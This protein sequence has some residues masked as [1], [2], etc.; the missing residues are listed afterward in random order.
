MA[1]LMPK[2]ILHHD[3][4]KQLH[5]YVQDGHKPM[6]TCFGSAQMVLHRDNYRLHQP[7]VF[8]EPCCNLCIHLSAMLRYSFYSITLNMWYY[9]CQR[10]FDKPVQL[11]LQRPGCIIQQHGACV[12]DTFLYAYI[13]YHMLPTCVLKLYTRCCGDECSALGQTAG[14]VRCLEPCHITNQKR[15]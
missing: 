2:A 14:L 1:A 4:L 11:V 7:H 5:L 10:W 15:V 12:S 9:R 13:W 6:Y 8:L 3:V